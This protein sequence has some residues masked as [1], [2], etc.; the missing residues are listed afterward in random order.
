MERLL[1]PER[2]DCDPAVQHCEESIRDAF[3]SGLR[4][5]SVRQRLLENETLDLTSMF[6]QARALVSAQKNSESYFMDPSRVV[7]ASYENS[8]RYVIEEGEIRPDPERLKPLRELPV[9]H[10]MKSLRRILGL[11]AY[12][13]R[14]I[15]DY[16]CKIRPLSNTTE[17]PI[18]EEAR[19]A[20]C[21]IKR[22]IESAAV[23]AIDESIP[24]E[25]ETDASETATAA[26][27]TQDERPVGGK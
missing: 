9:P 5:P 19:K 21:Q 6:D 7:C 15:Y 26:V 10:D 4:S 24:F 3:I 1:R 27:L 11:F 8:E 25:L 18:S 14:W 13:S 12:Y 23:Y 16:S 17:F 20:F 22:D 2:F